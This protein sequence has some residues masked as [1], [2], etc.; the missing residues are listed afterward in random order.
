[1]GQ[2]ACNFDFRPKMMR[3]MIGR[4]ILICIISL[5][6]AC[7]RDNGNSD[8][9]LIG[10]LQVSLSLGEAKH[11]KSEDNP[12]Y[13]NNGNGYT[14][15][16]SAIN[17]MTVQLYESLDQ[18]PIYIHQAT[19][20]EIAL[21]RTY[22]MGAKA[23]FL[24][25]DIPIRTKY[26]EVLINQFEQA[27]PD[28]NLLQASNRD[29]PAPPAMTRELIPYSGI[30]SNVTLTPG[31]EV[32]TIAA[33]VKVG[34]VL[35]RLEITPGFIS[36]ID[37]GN[38]SYTFDWTAG[39]AGR[40]KAGG[41]TEA[42]IGAA[43][44]SARENFKKQHNIEA[45]TS[46]IYSYRVTLVRQTL[47]YGAND[48]ANN[49]IGSYVNYFKQHLLSTTLVKNTNND[50]DSWHSINDGGT[51]DYEQN[52]A[53]SNLFD[54]F[55]DFWDP[56]KVIAYHFFP[57]SVAADATEQQVK[58]GMPHVILRLTD[59]S[60]NY[61]RWLTIRT[62]L[63]TDRTALVT[64]FKPGYCYSFKLADIILTPWSLALEVRIAD[65]GKTADSDPVIKDFDQTSNVPEPED[66]DYLVELTVRPWRE[67][68][69]ETE[70]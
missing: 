33:A 55:T 2:K 20:Q 10:T 56:A 47:T 53:H 24:I 14:L 41:F 6:T 45:S 52:G 51:A 34:P 19:A 50:K 57:Q 22:P 62:F 66:S 13:D 16:F 3:Q 8:N 54:T 18:A 35:S 67:K 48:W 29:T 28:I 70:F 15:P 58:E 65:N 5:L 1:M 42:L 40:A 49:N 63:N 31:K 36:I 23:N 44:A 27:N 38:S 37:P 17:T 60:T 9:D 59:V 25:S 61:T 11:S 69:I 68:D 7:N 39:D 43:E 64:S 12:I 4:I 26:V 30:T 46:A 32:I 21:I